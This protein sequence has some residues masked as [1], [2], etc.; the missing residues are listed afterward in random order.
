M[1]TLATLTKYT[2]SYIY[3]RCMKGLPYKS[4]QGGNGALLKKTLSMSVTV[5]R[6]NEQKNVLGRR[7][8]VCCSCSGELANQNNRK[9]KHKPQQ[10]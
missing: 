9:L 3:D 6:T 4:R 1:F 2:D 8:F 7:R 10:I 5:E